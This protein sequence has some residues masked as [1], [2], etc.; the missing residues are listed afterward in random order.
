M[1]SNQAHIEVKFHDLPKIVSMQESKKMHAQ[2][3]LSS[4]KEECIENI[5]SAFFNLYSDSGNFDDILSHEIHP[6]VSSEFRIQKWHFSIGPKIYE[7]DAKVCGLVKLLSKKDEKIKKLFNF[8]DLKETLGTSLSTD[9]PD[10]D[11]I[12]KYIK[13]LQGN[14]IPK[15]I[16]YLESEFIPNLTMQIESYKEGVDYFKLQLC[17][18]YH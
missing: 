6:M 17:K 10:N 12:T 15:L 8:N 1:A 16:D 13:E 18:A 7:Q 5:A 9:W 4:L 14:I 2:E 11:L 3:I